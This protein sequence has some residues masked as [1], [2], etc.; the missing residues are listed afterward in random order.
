MS[1]IAAGS[2]KKSQGAIGGRGE[3]SHS[4]QA[5]IAGF[6]LT[7]RFDCLSTVHGFLTVTLSGVVRRIGGHLWGKQVL[8]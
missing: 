4:R 5:L 6:F 2:S 7:L 1:G 8:R 3:T